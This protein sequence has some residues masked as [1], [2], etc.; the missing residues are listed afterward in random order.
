MDQRRG[1][2][3]GKRVEVVPLEQVNITREKLK[4][5][6]PELTESQLKRA[7]QEFLEAL[8]CGEMLVLA[9][10]SRDYIG[11]KDPDLQKITDLEKTDLT[12]NDLNFGDRGERPLYLNKFSNGYRKFNER[13]GAEALKVLL[14]D[15]NIAFLSMYPTKG[16]ELKIDA[17][18]NST[19]VLPEG[20]IEERDR[21]NAEAAK[22]SAFVFET[23]IGDI[24]MQIPNKIPGG[25]SKNIPV[26][27]AQVC[28]FSPPN[29]KGAVDR[30][31]G[32][33]NFSII[34]G[35]SNSEFGN[36]S[37][38]RSSGDQEVTSFASL[39]RA[40]KSEPDFLLNLIKDFVPEAFQASEKVSYYP[41]DGKQHKMKLVMDIPGF[42]TINANGHFETEENF[43]S[44]PAI[45]L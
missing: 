39:Y 17:K 23:R 11:A 1:D 44:I 12:Q 7:K 30:R 34:L 25:E 19:V 3:S 13:W 32:S 27:F 18:E 38:N 4:E 20:Y 5:N 45:K 26:K 14:T 2:L 22:G 41:S 16:G 40:I 29:S 35:G 9:R 8:R 21:R 31:M 10:S 37:L 42:P 15:P 24:R 33:F 28:I 43:V 6:T 36:L